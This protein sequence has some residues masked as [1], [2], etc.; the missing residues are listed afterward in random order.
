[1]S[2]SGCLKK[3]NENP[4]DQR[5]VTIVT[6]IGI[7]TD[8]VKMIGRDRV[9]VN[10]LIGHGGDPHHYKVSAEAVKLLSNAD[11]IFYNGL[12]L[13]AQMGAVLKEM[14]K[15]QN[16]VAVTRTMPKNRLLTPAKF[17]GRHDPHV[18]FDVSLW[19]FAVK[20]IRDELIAVDPLYRDYYYRNASRYLDK[21]TQ[22][23]HDIQLDINQIDR[24]KRLLVTGHDAFN[25]F[26]KAYGLFVTGVQG[27]STESRA[28]I[29]SIQRLARII[30]DH[31]IPAIF[32]ESSVPSH[33]IEDVQHAVSVKG[34]TVEI[35]GELFSDAMGKEGTIEGTYIG[36]MKHNVK[37][38]I[39]SLFIA[40][41]PN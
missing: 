8:A 32:S 27:I 35:G 9:R 3:K 20:V 16:V 2:V 14:G 28:G 30:T 23:H 19:L 10:E 7:I 12:H 36:M 34:K 15:H 1:M 26:G 11:I 17:Q 6:T 5:N 4:I 13:E 41:V 31:D 39:S 38:I 40:D 22:L 21:M 24:Q 29:N 18:W 25:Y 37:I 33:A